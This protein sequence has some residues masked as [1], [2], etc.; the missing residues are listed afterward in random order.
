MGEE[1]PET[2]DGLG[3]D[4][5]DSVGDDFAVDVDVA[6]SVGDTPDAETDQSSQRWDGCM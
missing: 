5:E 6:G 1:E 2:E 3:K 4:V